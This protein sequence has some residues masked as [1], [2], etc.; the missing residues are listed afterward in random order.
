ME[1]EREVGGTAIDRAI[2]EFAVVSVV[3][4]A[5]EMTRVICSSVSLCFSLS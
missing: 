1:E 3:T 5:S 2:A 4:Q